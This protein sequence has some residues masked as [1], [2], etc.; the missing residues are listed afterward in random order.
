MKK[1]FSELSLEKKLGLIALTLGFLALFGANPYERT[2]TSL[3]TK[4]IAYA[5]ESRNSKIDVLELAGWLI[6]G[7]A[8]YKLI[9]VRS[10]NSFNEYHIPEAQ[11]FSVLA[12]QNSPLQKN[13][14]IILYSDNEMEAA[15][16]WFLLKS[17]GYK[18]V[19]I[20]SGGLDSWKN[21]I[22]FPKASANA[23]ADEQANY[24]KIKEISKHFGGVPQSVS[25][26]STPKTPVQLPKLQAPA[27]SNNQ[28]GAAAPRKRKEGC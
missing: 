24:E 18:A 25:E 20:L 26:E 11:N 8:D 16:A 19:Y 27:S 15:Q 17:K 9:D 14:K 28:A 21:R 6:Q 1:H 3:N 4:E 5:S 23:S 2:F 10:E 7:K 12:L 13:E 22:L